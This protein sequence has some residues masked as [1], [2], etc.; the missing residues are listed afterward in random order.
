MHPQSDN[1]T[2][3]VVNN[4]SLEGLASIDARVKFRIYM[5]YRGMAKRSHC[6]CST[7]PLKGAFVS[8]SIMCVISPAAPFLTMSRSVLTS[9]LCVTLFLLL[10]IAALV[11]K[12]HVRGFMLNTVS[13]IVTVAD[14]VVVCVVVD[15]EGA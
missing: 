2:S 14:R 13:S 6:A 1:T 9:K 8:L 11:C 3:L 5:A 15:A 4:I 7:S 12:M 10:V